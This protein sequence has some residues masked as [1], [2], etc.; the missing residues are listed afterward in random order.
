MA[1]P[2]G[3]KNTSGARKDINMKAA[4]GVFLLLV[5]LLILAVAPAGAGQNAE[6]TAVKAA[7][8]WL[9]LVD[10]GKYAESW[11]ESAQMF[12]AAVT[13]EKWQ[14]S[15]T[16]VRKPLGKLVSRSVKAKQYTR[17][18]PGAPDGEYVVIQYDTSFENKKSAVEN[19]YSHAGQGWEVEGVRVLHTIGSLTCREITGIQV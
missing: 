9:A 17:S 1:A 4:T 16:A 8:Q 13:K 11:G 10:G 3:G 12:R 6:D 18:L 7:S 15:L 2:V 5:S 19:R 14:E